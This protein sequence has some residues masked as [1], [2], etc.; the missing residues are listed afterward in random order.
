VVA[1]VAVKILAFSY[2]FPPMAV[3]RS[4]QVA[5]LLNALA[6]CQIIVVCCEDS[7]RQQDPTLSLN[8][9]PHI[10]Q[11]IKIPFQTYGGFG[12]YLVRVADKFNLS[13][14]QPDPWRQWVNSV[15]RRFWS[16]QIELNFEPDLLITFGQPMSDHL[17]GLTYKQKT[18]KPWIAH[19]SDPWVDNPFRRDNPVTVWLNRRMERQVFEAADALIFTSPETIDLVMGHHPQEWRKKAHYV[20]HTYDPDLYNNNVTPPDDCYLLRSVGNFYGPRTPKPLFEGVE[21]IA[22]QSPH[23]LKD[24]SIELIGD[25]GKFNAKS[26]RAAQQIIKCTSTVPYREAIRL[27]QQAHCLLAID[28]PDDISVFFPSKL[29]EYIGTGRFIVAIAPPGASA[30]IVKELGGTVANPADVEAVVRA[31]KQILRQ[32]PDRLSGS[33][34]FYS[35]VS[36]GQQMIEIINQVLS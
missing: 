21:Q 9:Q 17:F 1:S 13:W 7:F 25:L 16:G 33:T 2:A 26:Y 28:A 4:M 15:K 20:P 19:F 11:I 18:G 3:P 5:R 27:M 14:Q 10:E 8:L 30:R 32:R 23:L 29:V 6:E 12:G 22:H 36:V 31:I 24:V 35:R 34:R